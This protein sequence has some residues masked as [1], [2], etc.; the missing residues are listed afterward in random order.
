[1]TKGRMPAPQNLHLNRQ[2]P[3]KTLERI[4]HLRILESGS[5]LAYAWSHGRVIEVKEIK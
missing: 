1:M 4:S 3:L 2:R 5:G